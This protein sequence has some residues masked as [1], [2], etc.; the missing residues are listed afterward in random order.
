MK[1]L[2]QAGR[3]GSVLLAAMLLSACASL[4]PPEQPAAGGIVRSGRLALNVPGQPQQSFS[5]TFELR[6]KP[7]AGT[8][9]LFTPIGGT[10]AQ[11]RWQ[12]GHAVLQVPGQ[13]DQSVKGAPPPGPCSWRFQARICSS[14]RSAMRMAVC[15]LSIPV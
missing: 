7:E 14:R 10:A 5:A 4:P 13:P 11:L 6:G 9:V 8:L 2:A 12:P 1:V 3:S 15:W